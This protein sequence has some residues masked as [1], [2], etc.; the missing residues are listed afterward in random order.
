M[1][2]E[3]YKTVYKNSCLNSTACFEDF[4]RTVD[5]VLEMDDLLAIHLVYLSACY[6]VPGV[7]EAFVCPSHSDPHVRQAFLFGEI[8]PAA[9]YAKVE[10]YALESVPISEIVC[11]VVASVLMHLVD[12]ALEHDARATT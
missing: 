4:F 3:M 11:G 9:A 6:C 1:G 7:Y 10:R 5:E 2:P 12:H 8:S